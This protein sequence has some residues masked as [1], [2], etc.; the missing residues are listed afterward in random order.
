MSTA[1]ERAEVIVQ[2][3]VN[4]VVTKAI[5]EEVV[6]IVTKT[7]CDKLPMLE[8]GVQQVPTDL[9]V[10]ERAQFFLD[11]MYEIVQNFI[12]VDA[13]KEVRAELQSYVQDQ[14]STAKDLAVSMLDSIVVDAR[15]VKG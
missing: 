9:S 11:R 12:K 7:Y 14:I 15:V 8:G 6:T 2:A 13:E 10:E 5:L 3:L 4:S 1:L